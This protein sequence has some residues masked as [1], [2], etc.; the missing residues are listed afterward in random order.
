MYQLPYLIV[1]ALAAL[2][3]VFTLVW[4]VQLRTRNA[5]I[6]DA[7]WS[8]SFPLMSMIYFVLIIGYTPRQLLVLGVVCLWGFRLGLYL[9]FRTLGHAED[10]RYTALREEWGDQQNRRMLAFYYKQAVAA[11]ILSVPFILIMINTTPEISVYEITGAVICVIGVI[12]E[13]IADN[14]LKKFKSIPENKGKIMRSGLWSWSRHPNYFFEWL[15]WVGFFV[16]SLFSA[17]GWTSLFGMLLMYYLLTK[18]TGIGYTEKQM[19]ISRGEAFIRY[20]QEVSAFF[21][22]PPRN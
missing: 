21:P 12:G 15:V 19:L 1:I 10:V 16:M 11:V 5:A 18:R 6:I 3:L 2:I 8:M 7:I 9:L 22:R 14:Q 20:Q 17:W 4:V 13:S